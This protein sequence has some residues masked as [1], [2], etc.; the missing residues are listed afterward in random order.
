MLIA[1]FPNATKDETFPL[2]QQIIRFF[3]RHNITLAAEEPVAKRLGIPSLEESD[4]TKI[5]YSLTVGGDGTILRLAHRHPELSAPVLG[6]KLGGL[7]FMADV[8]V[9]HLEERLE[10]LLAGKYT[11]RDCMVIFGQLT[12]SDPSDHLVLSEGATGFAVNEV[13]LHRGSNPCLIDLEVYVDGVYLNTFSADGLII[14][15]PCGSTAYSLAAGG[16]ILT[17]EVNAYVLTP[18]CPHT[19]SNRPIVLMP[20]R[21]L[22]VHYVSRHAPIEVIFDGYESFAL[23][24]DSSVIL[25]R[26]PSHTFRL[27]ELE[28]HDAFATLRTKL[29]WS[30]QLRS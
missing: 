17:A 9:S 27:I 28:G 3:K 30:G 12:A 14:A 5:R 21:E 24:T 13:V 19:L 7:G 29:N 23:P 18:I 8:P 4:K 15:T 11:V 25:K 16:P 2:S 22:R 26:R 1:L 20:R 10:L 6:I